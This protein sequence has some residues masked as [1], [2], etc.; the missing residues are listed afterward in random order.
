MLKK[1]SEF[2]FGQTDFAFKLAFVT[3]FVVMMLLNGIGLYI[4]LHFVNKFW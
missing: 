1:V 4:V 2:I 3:A